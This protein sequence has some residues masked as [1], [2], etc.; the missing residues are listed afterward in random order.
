[1]SASEQMEV[2]Q[3]YQL[4]DREIQPFQVGDRTASTA[5]LAWF[6]EAVWRIEPEDV[7]DSICD[8]GGD[9][10]IDG[11]FVNDDENE[12]TIF[13]SKHRAKPGALQGDQ[14]LRNL[15]GAAA[16]FASS[17]SVDGLLASKPN[18]ELQKLVER[19]RIRERVTQ[20]AQPRRCVFVTNGILDPSGR[21]FVT[22]VAGQDPVLDVWDLP[23]IAPVAART[24]A[25]EFLPI[26]VTLDAAATP[27]TV[28]LAGGVEMVIA[29]VPASTLV[30]LPGIE[31]FT[32]FDR[33]VRLSLGNTR[34]NKELGKTIKDPTEHGLF[35]AY[36]NGL[37]ILTHTLDVID[38]ELH[39]DGIT[40]VNGCQSLVELK[41]HEADITGELRLLVKVIQV[42]EGTKLA[43]AVTYRSNNQNAVDIRDQRAT[44]VIQRDL[45][46]QVEE[47]Y[48]PALGYEVRQGDR[49]EAQE[50]IDNKT[51]AQFLM[52]IYLKEPWNA[53]RKVRLF[54]EDYRRIFNRSLT[55]HQI[56]FVHIVRKVVDSVRGNLRADLAGSFAS[57]RVTLANLIAE[58][59]RLSDGGALLIDKPEKWLPELT[60]QVEQLLSRLAEDVVETVNYYIDQQQSARPEF[61]PKVVFKAKPGVEAVQHEV[62]RDARAIARKDVEYLFSLEPIR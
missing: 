33:N 44:D 56:Y 10:G 30:G 29:L 5:L 1:M 32:L 58:V 24:Q 43:D 20:G 12:I 4:V 39:L 45:R 42:A 60:A 51:A 62:T 38:A 57:V 40:V 25:P 46:K 6:M 22:A 14:D 36:H 52:A 18:V 47:R 7:E 2:E 34:I 50:T 17:E 28:S 23:R 54:D 37:T 8:G 48:G 9:K 35:P 61:D 15:I 26:K 19:L 41:R 31:D 53:V 21:D 59:L 49:S 55:V 16:Y 27:S 11:L 3:S 13:Q